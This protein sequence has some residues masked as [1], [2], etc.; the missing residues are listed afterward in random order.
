M[1]AKLSESLPTPDCQ[2][3]L[4]QQE[5]NKPPWELTRDM[6]VR[7]AVDPRISHAAARFL[8]L[9]TEYS[10]W[11][12][13]GGNGR[14]TLRARN[15]WLRKNLRQASKNQIARWGKELVSAGYIWIQKV[16]FG[17]DARFAS[18]IFHLS[19]LVPKN[20]TPELWQ[21]YS[22]ADGLP[23]LDNI[24]PMYG[25]GPSILRGTAHPHPSGPHVPTQ[26][27]QSSP[28]MGNVLTGR[29][30][31]RERTAASPQSHVTPGQQKEDGP[32]NNF[33]KW[34]S[35]LADWFPS[36][37]ASKHRQLTE[38]LKAIRNDPANFE[39][40][41]LS[42]A[43]NGIRDRQKIIDGGKATKERVAA[44][45]AEIVAIERSPKSYRASRLKNGPRQVQA[46]LTRQIKA[47]EEQPNFPGA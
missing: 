17:K 28:S 29:Q 15:K 8:L 47:I 1:N 42:E 11:R 3:Q 27:D 18:H 41:M 25:D 22:V 30:E 35:S 43:A 12:M 33:A 19:C 4:K 36:R 21:A 23:E 24:V 31:D 9:I 39:R 10:F 5:A 32:D 44:L 6:Y 40:E 20:E 14:G 45:K 13:Y 7:A 16:T 34:E 26:V 46:N 37:L 38:K 2:G